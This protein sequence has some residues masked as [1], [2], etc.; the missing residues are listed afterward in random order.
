ME[1]EWKEGWI[2]TSFCGR[3]QVCRVKYKYNV[4]G[5]K[6]KARLILNPQVWRGSVY[7]GLDEALSMLLMRLERRAEV[8]KDQ[9]TELRCE[10]GT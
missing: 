3:E 5:Y 4:N 8:I 1:D 10:G 7:E 2:I 6:I 9:L